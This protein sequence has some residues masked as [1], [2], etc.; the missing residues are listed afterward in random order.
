MRTDIR[1]AGLSG[2]IESRIRL[3]AQLIAAFD[4]D[5]KVSSWDG[6]RCHAL[7]ADAEDTYGARSIELAARRGIA[8]LALSGNGTTGPDDICKSERALPA[9][10]LAKVLA[11][12]LARKTEGAAAGGVS[13]PVAA[14]AGASTLDSSGLVQLA[15]V[16][17]LAHGD[18][19]GR[20]DGIAVLLRREASRVSAVS[21][22]TLFAARD[23]LAQ[24]GWDFTPAAHESVDT[25]RALAT[26]SMALDAFCVSGA[27]AADAAFPPLPARALQLQDWP[28]LGSA[29]A[30]APWLSVVGMLQQKPHTPAQ[31][32]ARS[33]LG[34]DAVQALLWSLQASGALAPVTD[35]EPGNRFDADRPHDAGMMNVPRVAPGLLS[36]LM[37]RFGFATVTAS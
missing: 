5:A 16:P 17:A 13:A 20:I 4:I 29:A 8:V 31:L 33:G 36:R 22:D 10:S 27:L 26:T 30:P 28:D 18:I 2:Q 25:L 11:Q 34:P 9:A 23:R 15:T 35:A 12:C 1:I 7:V 37:R 3:A 24:P 32:V 6:T 21:R 19:V 14:E